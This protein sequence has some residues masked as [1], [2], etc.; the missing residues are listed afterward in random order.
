MLYDASGISL[1][2]NIALKFVNIPFK[3]GKPFR[4]LY[5][6]ELDSCFSTGSA[7]GP[8]SFAE[9]IVDQIIVLI[10]RIPKLVN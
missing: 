7:V 8:S 2:S 6:Y 4:Y 3:S 1:K 5:F 10:C 9:R